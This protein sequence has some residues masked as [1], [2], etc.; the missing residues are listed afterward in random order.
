MK[1]NQQ[2][3]KAI[4]KIVEDSIRRILPAV[5]NEVLLKTLANSNVQTVNEERVQKRTRPDDNRV[6]S[7]RSKTEKLKQKINSN[8]AAASGKS[9][10]E[11]LGVENAG[12]DFYEAIQNNQSPA[13]LIMQ[14]EMGSQDLGESW[15]D[16]EQDQVASRIN[17]LAPGLRH[18]AEGMELPDVGEMWGSESDSAV[19]NGPTSASFQKAANI[20]ID[21]NRMKNVIKETSP[22]SKKVSHEDADNRARFEEQRIKRMREKLESKVVSR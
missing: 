1:D 8:K 5:M 14:E 20:G 17:N 9:L 16:E 10:R 3:R 12:A 6:P 2:L 13:S 4:D 18:L 21:F 15:D 7:L 22:Q 19:T 11:M